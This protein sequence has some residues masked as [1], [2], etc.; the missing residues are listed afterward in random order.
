MI[1]VREIE[2]WR[3]RERRREREKREKKADI[4]RVKGRKR[5]IMRERMKK[6]QELRET[7]KKNEK[8]HR[9]YILLIVIESWMT[10][11]TYSV[12]TQPL[13]ETHSEEGPSPW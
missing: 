7:N 2:R 5:K 12:I 8:H 1:P 3:D 10:C 6:R 13:L 11:Q 9:V 4:E